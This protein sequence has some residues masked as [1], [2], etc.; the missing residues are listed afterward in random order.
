MQRRNQLV[1]CAITVSF[2][3]SSLAVTGGALAGKKE[4]EYMKKYVKP[5]IA[6][7]KKAYKTN[8][9]CDLTFSLDPALKTE[10]ELAVI[11]GS[12]NSIAEGIP[13]YCTD[14]DSKSAACKMKT[15]RIAK[16]EPTGFVFKG[17]VGT[18]NSDGNIYIAWDQ[19]AEKIDP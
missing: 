12:A 3:V 17:T 11:R 13:K 14:K 1:L 8:C 9:G 6:A 2:V 10:G 5:A 4:R 16:S 15:L 19:M 7:A 18:A